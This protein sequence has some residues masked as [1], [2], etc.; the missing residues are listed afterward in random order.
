MTPTKT[1][2][3]PIFPELAGTRRFTVDEYHRLGEAGILG[4]EDKVELLDGYVLYKR[5]YPELT[6]SDGPF[7]DWRWLRR[8]SSAEYHRMLELGIIDREEKVELLDGYVVLKMGQSRAHRAAV[9]RLATRLAPRLPGRW[10][11]M[12]QAPI[13]IGG[14]DP[15]PDGV[16]VR[17]AD[18]D[19]DDRDVGESD[20]GIVIEV[21]GST[22]GLDRSAK[23]RFYAAAGIPVYWIVNVED[24]QVEVYADPDPAANPP[25][26]RTRTDYRPGDSVPIVLD[27][28]PAGSIPV[29]DLIP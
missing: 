1:T 14:M 15:E 22:L 19:Y 6:P 16:V 28:Q 17:G 8:W 9:L 5:D 3:S 2:R 21:A 12:T 11:V 7:P 13:A 20:F 18:S 24:R 29:A 26:Y 10:V 23:G 4:P 25:A 27:G